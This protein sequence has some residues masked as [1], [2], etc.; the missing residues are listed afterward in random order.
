MTSTYDFSSIVDMT[1]KFS[2]NPLDPNAHTFMNQH[3]AD[4]IPNFERLFVDPDTKTEILPDHELLTT[5]REI[6]IEDMIKHY[7]TQT[8][9]TT[10]IAPIINTAALSVVYHENNRRVTKNSMTHAL[11]DAIAKKKNTVTIFIGLSHVYFPKHEA[12]NYLDW[13]KFST[14]ALPSPHPGHTDTVISPAP[15]HEST[16]TVNDLT[17]ALNALPTSFATALA[18]VLPNQPAQPGPPNPGHHHPHSNTGNHHDMTT[19][20][21][22]NFNPNALPADVRTRYDNKNNGGLIAGSTVTTRYSTG[23]FYHPEG[24]DKYIL[25]D[26][27]FFVAREPDQKGLF[28]SYITC[29]NTS[30]FAVRQWYDAITRH[31]LDHGYYCHPLYS[32]RKDHG[33][34]WGFQCGDDIDD[35][36]PQRLYLSLRK[37]SPIIF[38]L[39]MKHDM[40]P[41]ESHAHNILQICYGDGYHALKSIMQYVHPVFDNNP[42]RLVKTFPSQRD[43]DLLV[44]YQIFQDFLQLRAFIMNITTNLE[45]K[46]TLDIFLD[47]LKHSDFIHRVTREERHNPA[48]RHKYTGSQIVDTLQAFLNSSDSPTN[49][50]YQP[51]TSPIRRFNP[52]QN[53]NTSSLPKQQTIPVQQMDY[54]CDTNTMDANYT[55]K[56]IIDDVYEL[57]IPTD[58]DSRKLF[59]KY[60]AAL[61]KI[62]KQP[63]DA[64]KQPCLACDGHNH[65]F[66]DC[67][68]L[69]NT[70]FLQGHFI[71]YKQHKKR[72]E[73][74]MAKT[75]PNTHGTV[76][77]HT[78]PR[79][80]TINSHVATINA[81]ETEYT[82]DDTQDDFDTDQDFQLGRL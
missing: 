46:N 74:A 41:K 38:N 50:H 82:H 57:F 24:L 75:F 28:R 25:S 49:K 37:M 39:L 70:P 66:A 3:Y 21:I 78:S 59:T 1:I 40:F 12:I 9:D 23:F 10:S 45:D 81:V 55:T 6:I 64:T 29:K 44:Y 68:V 80:H 77:Q 31:L 54:D 19:T 51:S 53:R 52:Y 30:K 32:F 20:T 60:E 48:T 73:N 36:L 13:R 17:T 11:L 62:E 43:L 22:Y 16:I 33:G 2:P 47:N 26:G 69:L 65:K 61:N 79:I 72:E 18:H 56:D 8:P 42:A 7:A 34:K 15:S 63:N 58:K 35:D 4:A 76:Q 27:S 14:S 5:L 67:P 71:R